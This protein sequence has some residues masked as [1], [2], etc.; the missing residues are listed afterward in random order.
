MEIYSHDIEVR[1]SADQDRQHRVIEYKSRIDSH[2]AKSFQPANISQFLK[3]TNRSTTKNIPPIHFTMQLLSKVSPH[4][5][6]ANPRNTNPPLQL[7]ALTTLLSAASALTLGPR[8]NYPFANLASYPLSGCQMNRDN[9]GASYYSIGE[10][11]CTN[12]TTTLSFQTHLWKPCYEGDRAVITVYSSPDCEGDEIHD[13]VD[14]FPPAC[15]E[16]PAGGQS[17]YFECVEPEEEDPSRV[18]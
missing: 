8:V 12:V 4:H 5:H 15:V 16:D 2:S 9:S 1:G 14:Y 10:A 6:Q 3:A 13:E 7:T 18:E 11:E 17:I